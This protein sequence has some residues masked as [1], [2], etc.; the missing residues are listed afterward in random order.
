MIIEQN[1]IDLISVNNELNKKQA[2]ILELEYP[3][4]ENYNELIIG[5]NLSIEETNLLILL[6]G[7]FALKAQEMIINNYKDLKTFTNN[8]KNT[9]EIKTINNNQS[10]NHNNIIIYCDGAC[11]NNPGK[12]GSGL[13]IYKNNTL[14]YLLHGEYEENGTNNTAELKALYKALLLVQESNAK[15]KIIYSDSKYSIDCISKWAYSWKNNGWSKK[16]G[17]IK[18]L[19]IIKLAHTLYNDIKDE[20][21]LNHVKAHAGIEGNELADRMA[22]YAIKAKKKNFEEYTYQSISDVLS[23][24]RG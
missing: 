12:A 20:I 15:D 10:N 17:E 8:Q 2:F 1:F 23:L 9:K 6:Q 16:G 11:S 3:L 5:K 14:S 13:A 19:E 7:K 22:S 21:S 4:V 24:N 18:N